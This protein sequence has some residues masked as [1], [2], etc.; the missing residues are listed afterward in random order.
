MRTPR[1][2]EVVSREYSTGGYYDPPEWGRDWALVRCR[3]KA[4][5]KVLAVKWWRRCNDPA[6][7]QRHRNLLRT[8]SIDHG[9]NPFAGILVNDVT[10]TWYANECE[11]VADEA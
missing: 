1:L 4:R 5:A 7:R 9:E 11:F 6:I 8:G 10:D 3:T 2:F